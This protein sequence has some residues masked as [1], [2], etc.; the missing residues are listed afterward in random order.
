MSSW[1]QLTDA[2]THAPPIAPPPSAVIAPAM[3]P[4]A[5]AFGSLP[6]TARAL[7]PPLDAPAVGF[8]ALA[9]RLP[10]R[11]PPPA[12]HQRSKATTIATTPRSHLRFMRGRC[13]STVPGCTLARSVTRGGDAARADPRAAS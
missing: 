8:A 7:P 9:P 5:P 1:L 3:V 4:A 6:R 10:P 13:Y 11:L 2:H 12:S